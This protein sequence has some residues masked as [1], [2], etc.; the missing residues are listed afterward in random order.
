MYTNR[1]DQA[2]CQFL[3]LQVDAYPVRLCRHCDEPFL[4]CWTEPFGDDPVR[5]SL[6][7]P[8]VEQINEWSNDTRNP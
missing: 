7:N 3:L 6:P 5:L 1:R 2:C 4:N 8:G